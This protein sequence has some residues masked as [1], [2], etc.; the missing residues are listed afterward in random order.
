ML[1]VSVATL[2]ITVIVGF[3]KVIHMLTQM[4]MKLELTWEWYLEHHTDALVGG[5]R[6]TDPPTP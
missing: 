6:R 4:E 5:R 3:G 2:T 1:A